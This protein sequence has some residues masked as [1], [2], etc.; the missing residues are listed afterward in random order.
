MTEPKARSSWFATGLA[1]PARALKKLSYNPR[2]LA[3]A[4]GLRL[5]N[6]LRKCY[7]SVTSGKQNILKVNLGKFDVLFQVHS[8]E[9]YRTLEHFFLSFEKDF[10]DVLLSSLAEGDVCLDVGSSLGEFAVP[11]SKAVGSSGLVLA[12]E[13]ERGAC[14]QLEANLKLNGSSNVRLLRT[15]LGDECKESCLSWKDGSCPSLAGVT[16]QDHNVLSTTAPGATNGV[17]TVNVEIG[18]Q[19]MDRE[20][21]P[22]PKAVKIDVEG[23]EFQVIRGLS[24]TLRNATCTLLCCEIHPSFLPAGTTPQLII[25]EVKSLGF[26]DMVLGERYAQIHMI[27]RKHDSQA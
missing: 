26:T 4:R 8:A 24:R 18:D 14:E 19:L 12:V 5:S 1:D 13:P 21:L 16:V 17:E 20:R 6:F 25:D 3:V 9:E 7:Q 27:A 11:L 22:I 10:I 23:Y 2:L 15:A